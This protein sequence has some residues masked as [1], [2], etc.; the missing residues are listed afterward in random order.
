M[1][2][3]SS[4]ALGTKACS[5]PPKGLMY[6]R[7]PAGTVFSTRCFQHFVFNGVFQTLLGERDWSFLG[8]KFFLKQLKSPHLVLLTTAIHYSM[9]FPKIPFHPQNLRAEIR[10]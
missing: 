8:G 6:K 10:E 7:V 9:H 4:P 2:A 5:M 1:H 3:S